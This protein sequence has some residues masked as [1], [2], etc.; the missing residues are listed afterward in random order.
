MKRKGN[1]KRVSRRRRKCLKGTFSSF[2]NK[3][4]MVFRSAVEFAYF[5]S[6][7]EDEDVLSYEVERLEYIE[8]YHP[9]KKKYYK[10]YPDVFVKYRDG[11]N[12]IVEVKA[13]SRLKNKINITKA[14]AA[15][16]YVKTLYR[17]IYKI[18]T[19]KDIFNSQ[20]DYNDLKDMIKKSE[21]KGQGK[22][23]LPQF[24]GKDD[25]DESRK[26]FLQPS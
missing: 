15:K 22:P 5:F 9:H 8:Y 11:H 3:T 10:Y 23:K 2:K 13:F 14:E 16:K 17:T 1:K 21:E 20:K 26:L 6:L 25:I 18:V 24:K 19:E 12:E 4:V 7:E